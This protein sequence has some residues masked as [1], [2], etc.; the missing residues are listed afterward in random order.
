MERKN[1]WGILGSASIAARLIAASGA[2]EG[3]RFVAVASR[4]AKKAESFAAAYGLPRFYGSY[5]EMLDG[6]EIDFVYNPLPN[7]L[8]AKWTLEAVKRGLPVL[9][10]KPLATSAREAELILNR[11]REAG[12]YVAE[13]FMYRCHPQIDALKKLIEGGRLGKLSSVGAVFSFYN[14][15]PE[16]NFLK[17]E[18]G[19][20][21]LADV[22]CYCVDFCRLIAGS[23][24]VRAAAV[25]TGGEVDLTLA[26]A[27]LFANGVVG[28]SNVRL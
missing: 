25:Q 22:G 12:V 5:E 18:F 24:P 19:G 20:G 14:D 21:S 13:G 10:E 4:D 7:H 26:G 23:E 9:C 8:H 15:D 27:L 28:Q 2:S 11:S 17:A 3:A 6:G 1:R 16:A